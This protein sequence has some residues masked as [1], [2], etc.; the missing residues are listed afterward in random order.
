MRQEKI[1]LLLSK[2]ASALLPSLKGSVLRM[3]VSRGETMLLMVSIGDAEKWS[4][5]GVV[6]V[7]FLSEF[8]NVVGSEIFWRSWGYLGTGFSSSG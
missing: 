8:S 3:K 7:G 6:A 1:T 5:S 2:A 4:S